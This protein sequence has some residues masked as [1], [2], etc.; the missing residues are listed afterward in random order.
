MSFLSVLFLVKHG[1]TPCKLLGL[2]SGSNISTFPYG[3]FE[4]IATIPLRILRIS[5]H[6]ILQVGQS[7]RTRSFLH[8]HL[9]LGLA[10]EMPQ[11]QH[12][13]VVDTL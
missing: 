11:N 4:Q 10:L 3:Q 13:H 7:I 9:L 2:A 5:V 8:A 12:F 1:I 6:S